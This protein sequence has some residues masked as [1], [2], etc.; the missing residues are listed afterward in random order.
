MSKIRKVRLEKAVLSR[1]SAPRSRRAPRTRNQLLELMFVLRRY[2]KRSSAR[3]LKRRKKLL[4]DF[5]ANSKERVREA[6]KLGKLIRSLKRVG[7]S[8][9]P[10]KVH[11]SEYS[12][13]LGK[14]D[15]TT[16]WK[17]FYANDNM[18]RTRRTGGIRE[19]RAIVLAD[20]SV[21]FEIA[22]QLQESISP[23]RR[24]LDHPD[25]THKPIDY[26]TE[27]GQLRRAKNRRYEGRALVD[28]NGEGYQRAHLF[29]HGYGDE[30]RAGLMY[31]P[32]EVNQILQGR[33]IERF[34]MQRAGEGGSVDVVAK[35]RSY[36]R[37]RGNT[38]LSEARGEFLL[39]Q[40]VYEFKVTRVDGTTFEA[41]IRFDIP[42]P[43][44][45]GVVVESN[46]QEF[47]ELAELL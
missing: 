43:P 1:D 18:A 28:E 19:Q 13:L 29:G 23:I 25:G 39:R 22:G 11:P 2:L 32:P 30:A 42:K 35:A 17:P 7:R 21:K 41:G 36:P 24:R 38:N 10:R 14:A 26:S 9:V 5:A 40:L 12:D 47:L 27:A 37:S 33:G 44:G 6:E 46:L 8:D 31:A 34:L 45:K 4:G 15:S 16:P 20:D 3:R